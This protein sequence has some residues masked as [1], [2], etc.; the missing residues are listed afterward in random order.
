MIQSVIKQPGSTASSN[1]LT[2]LHNLAAAAS[3][4]SYYDPDTAF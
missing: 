2:T 4:Q 1:P 3:Q